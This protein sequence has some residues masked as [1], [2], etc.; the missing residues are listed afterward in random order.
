MTRPDISYAISC[1]MSVSNEPL[2]QTWVA[3]KHLLWYLRGTVDKGLTYEGKK[4]PLCGYSD[5]N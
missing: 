2:E 1:L 5:A 4:K 3:L